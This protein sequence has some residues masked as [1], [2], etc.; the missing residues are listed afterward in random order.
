MSLTALPPELVSCVVAKIASNATRCS[1]ARCSRQ[2]YFRTIPHL[3]RNI[4]IQEAGRYEVPQDKRLRNL[5][6]LLLQRPD[7]AGLVRSFTL[8]VKRDS[9]AWETN[10]FGELEEPWGYEESE[11]SGELEELGDFEEAD[12][13]SSRHGSCL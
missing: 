11:E 8:H 6:S 4:E 2:L 13:P 10:Q 9:T 3:Y 7:L 5:A 12:I 1:L